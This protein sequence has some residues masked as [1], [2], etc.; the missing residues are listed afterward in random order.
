M[1]SSMARVYLGAFE[2]LLLLIWRRKYCSRS[3]FETIA[4]CDLP[5]R[6]D[7]TLCW[8]GIMHAWRCS[9]VMQNAE[10]RPSSNVAHR[11]E[12]GGRVAACQG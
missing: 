12:H 3:Q 2:F 4:L 10:V 7:V 11:H 8:L 5:Q 6:I 1:A 9:S